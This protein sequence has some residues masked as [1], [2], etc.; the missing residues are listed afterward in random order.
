[1]DNQKTNESLNNFFSEI[2]NLVLFTR[3]MGQQFFSVITSY[4]IHYTKLYESTRQ[5]SHF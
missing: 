1:M 2:G 4:S 3:N 5:A